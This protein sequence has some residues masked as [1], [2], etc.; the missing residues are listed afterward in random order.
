MTREL[1]KRQAENLKKVF[2]VRE[3]DLETET[4][5]GEMFEKEQKTKKRC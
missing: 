4:L 2:E 1:R 5:K 3:K